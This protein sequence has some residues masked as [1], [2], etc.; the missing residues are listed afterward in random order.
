MG[1]VV[2]LLIMEG[3]DY[4]ASDLSHKYLVCKW[5]ILK[6]LYSLIP[7]LILKAVGF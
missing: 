5:N 2:L 7:A 4:G 6:S 1:Y 3:S